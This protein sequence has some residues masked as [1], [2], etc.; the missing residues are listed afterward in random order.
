[1]NEREMGSG[2]GLIHCVEAAS[3]CGRVLGD[4]RDWMSMKKP[5]FSTD[6]NGANEELRKLDGADALRLLKR[7]CETNTYE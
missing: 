4:D 6:L 1:M 2:G 7:N 5:E 3:K